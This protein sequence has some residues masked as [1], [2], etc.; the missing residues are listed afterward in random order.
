[1][2]CAGAA[3]TLCGNE[4]V[5]AI[6]GDD[7]AAGSETGKDVEA[8]SGTAVLLPVAHPGDG[9]AVSEFIT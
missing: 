2:T 7:T 8:A 3:T 1:M 4:L 6:T 9:K 5:G